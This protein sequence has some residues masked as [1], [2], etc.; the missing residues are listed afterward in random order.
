MRER[1]DKLR[2][3]M[4]NL[5]FWKDDIYSADNFYLDFF[6]ED[7]RVSFKLAMSNLQSRAGKRET[8]IYSID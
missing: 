3:S 2:I 4:S 6:G 8:A 7:T 1:K 5:S